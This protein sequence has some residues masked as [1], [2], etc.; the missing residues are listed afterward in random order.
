MMQVRWL[1]WAGF[2][3]EAQGATLVIDLLGDAF[4]VV[5]AL[6]ERARAVPLPQLAPAGQGQSVAGLVTHLHRDHADAG[7][8]A[9]AL[10]PR[11][12]VFHPGPGGG[13]AQENM[14]LAQAE[15]EFEHHHLAGR[16]VAA[17]ETHTAGPFRITALPAVDGIGDPQV[18]WLVEADEQ[19]LLHLGDSMFH[20]YWWR[21]RRRH[22]PV[23]IALV[24]VN[25]ACVSFP[26]CQP[27]SPLPAA[28]DPAQAALAGHLIGAP[29]VIP[30]HY[31]GF[32]AAP[33]YREVPDAP[34]QFAAAA[35]QYPYQPA[36]LQPGQT[37]PVPLQNSTHDL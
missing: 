29:V 28:L 5:A 6:G 16:I 11:A 3:I 15:A 35:A 22:G 12:P 13:D 31:G 2:E 4:G 36:Q 17:W 9:A 32:E 18:S 25:G 34:G 19:R 27:A 24:P 14:W 10:A 23:D 7:A 26:H 1:G 37:W 20:G 30:M 8:L 33:H 21:L